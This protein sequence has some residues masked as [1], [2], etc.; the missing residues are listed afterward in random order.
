MQ[1]KAFSKKALR[2]VGS[3]PSVPCLQPL[4]NATKSNTKVH[5][6]LPHLRML[7]V[8][9]EGAVPLL[10]RQHAV[11]V[12]G[13]PA[14]P[15]VLAEGAVKVPRKPERGKRVGACERD[16]AWTSSSRIE[17]AGTVSEVA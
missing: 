7:A 15:V 1:C 2:C 17:W 6:A 11:V 10:A 9:V 14:Q 4:F 3:Q 13:P 8:A 16:D 5:I 12:P